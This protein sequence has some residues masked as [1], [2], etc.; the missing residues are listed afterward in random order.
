[1]PTAFLVW[2]LFFFFKSSQ[3]QLQ[4]RCQR[5]RVT[6][7]G[8]SFFTDSK[9]SRMSWFVKRKKSYLV[10]N[11]NVD[12]IFVFLQNP[13]IIFFQHSYTKTSSGKRRG[14]LCQFFSKFFIVLSMKQKKRNKLGPL[15]KLWSM[16]AKKVIKV[17]LLI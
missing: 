7:W 15:C 3:D 5:E 17:I 4:W 8:Y 13:N 11:S 12:T 2:L 16:R 9:N 1:M 6:Y 10:W 14:N